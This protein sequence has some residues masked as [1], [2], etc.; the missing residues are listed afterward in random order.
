MDTIFLMDLKGTLVT[1]SEEARAAAI[2]AYL[3]EIGYKG[4]VTPEQAEHAG[5]GWKARMKR[6]VP[7]VP[8]TP[9][10]A[11][12]LGKIQEQFLP[13][14]V[15][16]MEGAVEVLEQI[17]QNGDGSVLVSTSSH[18]LMRAYLAAAG[19]QEGVFRKKYSV[20][21]DA[22]SGTDP[23]SV[24]EEEIPAYKAVLFRRV[25][26]DFPGARHVA[27]GNRVGDGEAA[28]AAGIFPILLSSEEG[29]FATVQDLR[30]ILRYPTPPTVSVV[31][32]PRRL[33]P[34][35]IPRRA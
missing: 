20:L 32:R 6:L 15:K 21:D 7:D 4:R 9:A 34:L 31:E 22:L 16:P 29:E 3:S 25:V 2:N 11:E 8:A 5:Y 35:P 13:V 14:Y 27:V 1:G 33:V 28:V 18:R 26:A 19:I 12:R 24:R 30:E 17:E 23:S 10:A